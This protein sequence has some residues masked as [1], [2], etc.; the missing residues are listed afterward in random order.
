MWTDKGKGTYSR[1]DGS[2][3]GGCCGGCCGGGNVNRGDAHAEEVEL[4]T[5]GQR[6]GNL[7][8]FVLTCHA[9]AANAAMC[10]IQTTE[11]T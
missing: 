5:L 11:Y 1:R 2:A 9:A 7:S 10:G 4:G 6:C 8:L 3:G